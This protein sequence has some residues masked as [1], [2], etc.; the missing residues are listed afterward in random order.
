MWVWKLTLPRFSRATASASVNFRMLYSARHVVRHP[1]RRHLPL[2]HR[3]HRF[4]HS[5]LLLGSQRAAGEV[6]VEREELPV[7]VGAGDGRVGDA[8]YGQPEGAGRG[9]DLL[10]DARVLRRVAHDPALADLALAHLE[11]RLN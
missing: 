1:A 5:L 7:A 4:A 8:E 10:D 3:R 11:L 6:N 9:V 2:L